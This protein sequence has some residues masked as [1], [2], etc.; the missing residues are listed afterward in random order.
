MGKMGLPI[1][2]LTAAERA[3]LESLVSR[4]RTAQ[5][6]ALRVRIVVGCTSGVRNKDVAAQLGID[7]VT[8]S[9]WRWR[10]LADGLDGLRDEPRSGAPRTVDDARIEG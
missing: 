5:A 9:K 10:F 3:E 4:R 2:E 1:V 6:L 7:P 8:V